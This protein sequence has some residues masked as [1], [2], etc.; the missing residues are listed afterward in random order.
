MIS[1]GFLFG[2]GISNNSL[3][4]TILGTVVGIAA[5]ALNEMTVRR[6]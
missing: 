2:S 1:G 5:F 3:L 4:G 6:T